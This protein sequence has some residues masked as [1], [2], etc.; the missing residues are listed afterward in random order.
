MTNEGPA[1]ADTA[2]AWA[3][4]RWNA[5]VRNRPLENIHR[6][7]LDTTWRQ[8]I[9]YFGGDPDAL[10][11]LPPHYDLTRKSGVG[12]E[13]DPTVSGSAPTCVRGCPPWEI[14]CRIGCEHVRALAGEKP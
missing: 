13:P 5:E 9:R 1:P 4:E 14:P 12:N 7:A 2:V 8:V 10:L 11:P 6:A 3:V